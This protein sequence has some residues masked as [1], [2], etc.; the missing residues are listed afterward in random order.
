MYLQRKKEPSA[1]LPLGI[2][3]CRTQNEQSSDDWT[4]QEELTDGHRPFLPEERHC[5]N[6]DGCCGARE[7]DRRVYW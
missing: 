7:S 4:I 3:I 1:E 2:S 5:Y 6:W